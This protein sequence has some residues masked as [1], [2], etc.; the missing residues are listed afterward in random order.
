MLIYL[1][2]AFCDKTLCICDSVCASVTHGLQN[3]S[4]SAK[5]IC[6]SLQKYMHFALVNP[7]ESTICENVIAKPC[8]RCIYC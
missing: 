5:H 4:F 3:L 8:E 1:P 7:W 6:E 2:C